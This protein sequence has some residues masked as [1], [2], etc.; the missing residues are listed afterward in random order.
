MLF[1]PAYKGIPL[2]TAT[3]IALAEQHGRNVPYAF[4]RKEAKDHGEGG[5]I[6][7]TPLQRA[8]ADRGRRDHRRHRD[9]RIARDHPR[10]RRPAG[11]PSRWPW[12]GRNAAGRALCGAGGRAAARA[13]VCEHHH[14][15]RPHRG[16]VAARRRHRAR[17]SAEQLTSLKAYRDRYGVDL[18]LRACGP[19]RNIASML[20]RPT[21]SPDARAADGRRAAGSA[22]ACR[23][24]RRLAGHASH[25]HRIKGRHRL[26]LGGRAGRRAL[27]RQRPAAV[28]A[29]GRAVLNQ[30][31]MEVGTPRRRR[32]PSRRPRKR[33]RSSRC[34]QAGQHD[35]FLLTTYTSVKDIEALRD[36]RL[37]QLQGQRAAAE[38]YVESLHSRLSTLQARALSFKPYNAPDARRMPDDLAEDLVRTL[39]EMRL[40]SD[41]LA[42]KDEEENDAARA[43][44][45]GHRALP[46]AAH[47]PQR[48][49]ASASAAAG[50]SE[51]A[52]AARRWPQNPPPPPAPPA[53]PARRPAARC[54]RRD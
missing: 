22:G 21:A 43:V 45:R 35:S 38:Q 33:R 30:Q 25:S 14:T 6:V 26:P 54:A 4:N 49:S 41:A 39:N 18:S 17:I 1:G 42:A 53:P 44:P 13:Q 11:R 7:G 34:A 9:P 12:T 52:G 48:S 5:N 16:P 8:R 40:Q 37:D 31:G 2:V 29:A 27:R 20:L 47:D 19:S 10:R 36:E 46:R 51:A 3:A 28:R 24:A 32:H 23:L 50:V 15:R